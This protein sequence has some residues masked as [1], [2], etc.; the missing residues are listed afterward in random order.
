MDP[1]AGVLVLVCLTAFCSG[2]FVK[3][4]DCGS[5]SGKV[6]T[7]DIHPCDSQPCQLHKGD[8]YTVNVTFSSVVESPTSQ[9][10]VH[11]I[12][13]GV[14]VPFTI[15]EEDGCKSGIQ[16]PIQKQQTYH[17]QATLPVKA[18]Y[19]SIKLT[20]EWEL[21]DNNNNDLFCIKFPVQLV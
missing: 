11:G 18:E 17:Y 20:V 7:V 15:P 19:P 12:I 21:R 6:A 5:T 13:A 9:A 1:R 4:I 8:S 16:C 3:F 10:V 14:P 2:E